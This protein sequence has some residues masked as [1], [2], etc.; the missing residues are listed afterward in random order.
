M[1]ETV[2]RLTHSYHLKQHVRYSP[3]GKFLVYSLTKGPY[4]KLMYVPRAGGEEKALFPDRQDYIQQHPAWSPDGKQFAFTIS[5][6]H[7]TGRIGVYLCDAG[8]GLT[9]SNF[10]PWLMGGQDSYASWSPD[11]KQVVFVTGNQRLS[12]AQAD[13]TG[14]R[15]LGPTGGIQGQP[16]WVR[17]GSR[18][19]FSSSHDGNFE[20]YTIKPDGSDIVRLT[21]NPH[22]DY[23][24]VYSPDGKSIAF[25]SSRAGNYDLWMMRTEGSDL[26]QLTIDPALDDSAA[27]SPD[28]REI[29]FVS[30]RDGGYDIYRMALNSKA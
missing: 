6:G 9:F 17:H 16:C 11:G 14:R 7:R 2:Q 19:A 3:D 5:D 24:P 4:L 20:I 8:E 23:R 1:S 15:T 26:R 18:I 13:G 22:I 21:D 29:A 10:R 12:V 28:G 25:T 30:T 27:W